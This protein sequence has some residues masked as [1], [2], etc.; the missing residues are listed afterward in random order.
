MSD[1]LTSELYAEAYRRCDN[2]AERKRQLDLIMQVGE[3]VQHLTKQAF[4]S[5]TLRFARRPAKLAGWS[6]IHSFL[7]RGLAAFKQMKGGGELFF[8]T[9]YE[10]ERRILEQLFAYHPDPFAL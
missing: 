3:S 4:V 2:L 9:V 1:K 8:Q 10:R 5:T 6:N 7:E